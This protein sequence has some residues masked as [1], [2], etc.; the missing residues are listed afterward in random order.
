MTIE[1]RKQHLFMLKDFLKSIVM[2]IDQ[3]QLCKWIKCPQLFVVDRNEIM[4]ECMIS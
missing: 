1:Q 4:V 2:Q 3:E